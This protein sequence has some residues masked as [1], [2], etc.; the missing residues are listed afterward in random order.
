MY[1]TRI[2]IFEMQGYAKVVYSDGTSLIVSI[3]EALKLSVEFNIIA[4]EV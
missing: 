4:E 2:A 3:K 1:I